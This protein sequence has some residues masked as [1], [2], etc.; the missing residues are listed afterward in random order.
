MA[1]FSAWAKAQ[2]VLRLLLAVSNPRI[3]S[4]LV[5]HGFSD[6]DLDEGWRLLRDLRAVRLDRTPP[7]DDGRAALERLDAWENDWV[8]I[9]RAALRRHFPAIDEALFKRLPR[10]DAR[11]APLLVDLFLERVE[12]LGRGSAPQKKARAL[13][14]RRGLT[15]A[16]CAEGRALIQAA[17]GRIDPSASARVEG[18]GREDAEAREAAL[19]G[20]YLEWGA[21]AQ[22]KI[23]DRNLL[24]QLGFLASA[25][26]GRAGEVP[27]PLDAPAAEAAE[28][29]SS[30]KDAAPARA[31]ASSGKGSK[32]VGAKRAKRP[33]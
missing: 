6:A 15:P 9:T 32:G 3:G 29:G 28:A 19:W 24:R 8:P 30:V 33:R 31:Q 1:N 25:R 13:L 10:A 16:V 27:A 12:Q 22:R 23:K 18:D 14:E 4:V 7:P 20:F 11:S 26:S 5:A 17:R 2:R 21:I